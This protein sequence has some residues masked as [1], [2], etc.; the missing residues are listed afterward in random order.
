MVNATIGFGA[1]LVVL[2]LAAFGLTRGASVTAL[3][4]AFV[5]ALMLGLGLLGRALPRAATPAIIGA[6]VIAVLA[7]FGSMRGLAGFMAL[8]AGEPVDRPV[9][10]IAQTLT[11]LLALGYL[12]LG[13]RLWLRARGRPRSTPG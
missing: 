12:A 8:L 13:A 7:V 1:A 11:L 4:P 2:G 9:A 6:A 3:I 5:G 10:V